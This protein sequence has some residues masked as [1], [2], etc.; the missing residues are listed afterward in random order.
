MDIPEGLRPMEKREKGGAAEKPLT[1]TPLSYCATHGL[2]SGVEWASRGFVSEKT[3]LEEGGTVLFQ[4]S[5]FCFISP[6][7]V[8]AFFLKW[9][10]N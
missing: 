1:T 3:K 5:S 4:C 8:V 7:V 6:K 9:T 10:T 2:R